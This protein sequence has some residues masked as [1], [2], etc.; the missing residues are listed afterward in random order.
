MSHIL[1][2]YRQDF[3]K[4]GN[5]VISYSNSTH[6]A[7]LKLG[8]TVTPMGEGHALESFKQIATSALDQYE[9]FLDVDSG[10]NKEGKL[11]FLEEKCPI[12]SAVRYIDTH[13]YPSLHKRS[14]KFYDHV[15]FAVWDKRDI[16]THHDSVHWCPNA[17]DAKYFYKDVLPEEHDSRPL[18]I[19][20][21]GSKGG[22][23]RA[24][25]LKDICSRHDWK[26]DI[27]EIGKN[28]GRWPATAE[29][30]AQCKLLFNKGQKHDGPNQ[31]VIE[32][33][34]MNRPLLND[35]DPRDGMSELFE[36]GEHY[37]GYA[38]D[39]ELADNIGWCLREPSLAGSMAQRAYALVIAKHQVKHR[40]EQ[41]LEVTGV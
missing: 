39:S 27:R 24:D 32:S 30:M 20:F 21:F 3:D 14:A 28:G 37:L 34:L 16:F 41:I 25:V 8:H 2:G 5:P 31:R 23:D 4:H 6:L 15:F 17:S 13:G 26:V 1:L 22:I 9:L 29:A 36:E 18:D 38:S 12:P 11:A 10:R 35:R 7:L 33:M 19:G 40:V